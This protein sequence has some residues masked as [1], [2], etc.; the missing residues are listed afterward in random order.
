M[1]RLP[2]QNNNLSPEERFA[3]MELK[4]DKI[5][6]FIERLRLMAMVLV[7]IIITVVVVVIAL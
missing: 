4:I 3:L 2:S 6:Q 5:Y 7:G 1:S